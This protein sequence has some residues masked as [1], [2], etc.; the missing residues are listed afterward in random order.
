MANNTIPVPDSVAKHAHLDDA[1]YR[2]L[3]A[4]SVEDPEGFWAEQAERFIDWSKPWDTVLDWD[5]TKA[6]IKWFEGAELNVCHNCVDRHL[7]KRGD[8]VAITWEPDDPNGTVRHLTY[9]QL[10]KLVCEFANVLKKNGVRKGDRVCIYM[11]MVPEA[12]IAMLACAR[13]GAVH[14]VVFGGFSPKSIR[15][16][17]LDSDCRVVVTADEGMRGGKVVPLK[18][19]V[20]AA[21]VDCPDV[22][23]VLV[24]KHTMGEI[25]WHDDRDRWWHTEMAAVDADCPAEPMAAEDPLF[26]LYTSGSTGKPKGVLHT[27][28]GYILYAAITHKYVFDYHDG[29]IYWCT[30]DVGHRPHPSMARSPTARPRSCSRAYRPGP[31]P[32]ATGRSSTNTA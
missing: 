27:T 17:I 9:K 23:T 16:R 30:A 26:I 25:D 1:A 32:A 3:Y 14:S 28:G 22:R 13:I 6:H 4:R 5:Y 21:L 12:A 15:D 8:Q 20:D 11:P 2:E 24:L 18:K 31:M 7:E 10:H 19:N 29:D